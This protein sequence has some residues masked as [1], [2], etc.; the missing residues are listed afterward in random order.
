MSVRDVFA[1]ADLGV[2]TSTFT[3]LVG[4]YDAMIFTMTPASL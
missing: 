3:A 2:F 1:R 4:P